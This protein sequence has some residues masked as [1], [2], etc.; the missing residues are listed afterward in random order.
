MRC[1]VWR[2]VELGWRERDAHLGHR[3]GRCRRCWTPC[4]SRTQHG[5]RVCDG[6]ARLLAGHP[7]PEVR[8]EFARRFPQEVPPDLADVL[9]VSGPQTPGIELQN[10]QTPIGWED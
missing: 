5:H 9:A 1:R 6:C 4:H 7:D 3:P 8:A 2:P 10:D